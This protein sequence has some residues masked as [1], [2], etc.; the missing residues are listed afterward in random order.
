MPL[1]ALFHCRVQ[2]R[3]MQCP[4]NLFARSALVIRNKTHCCWVGF[5]GGKLVTFASGLLEGERQTEDTGAKAVRA[6]ELVWTQGHSWQNLV[7]VQRWPTR[8][9][10][11]GTSAGGILQEEEIRD[12]G[13]LLHHKRVWR[14]GI[15]SYSRRVKIQISGTHLV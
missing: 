2:D 10:T 14:L 7:V 4:F 12:L 3:L 9:G 8:E 6:G 1:N 11:E 5:L 13:V 15:H